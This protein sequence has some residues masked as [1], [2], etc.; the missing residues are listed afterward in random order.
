MADYNGLNL[1]PPPASWNRKTHPYGAITGGPVL[2]YNLYVFKK[3][4]HYMTDD[5]RWLVGDKD[6][7]YEDL[8]GYYTATTASRVMTSLL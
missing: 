5:S 1:P 2:G 3:A 8:S 6:E 4:E 7:A